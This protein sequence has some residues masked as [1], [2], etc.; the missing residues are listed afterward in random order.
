MEMRSLKTSDIFK[1][2]KILQKMNIKFEVS[3]DM[4]QEQMG[5]QFIQSILENLHKA[6]DEVNAFMAD[7]VGMSPKE[8]AEL[9]ITELMQVFEMFKQQKGVNTFLS[10]AGK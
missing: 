7:L 1:M 5:V 3:P 2:S 9:P 8:F 10:L 4:T 6:E